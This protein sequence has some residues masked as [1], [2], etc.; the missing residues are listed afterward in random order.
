MSD[1]ELRQLYEQTKE[2]ELQYNECPSDWKENEGRLLSNDKYYDVFTCSKKENDGI[3]NS[4]ILEEG[5]KLYHGSQTLRRN[6][7]KGI[8]TVW[9]LRMGHHLMAE[10]TYN[11]HWEAKILS[12][13]EIGK[14]YVMVYE[15]K[16]PAKLFLMNDI[17]NL[18][19]IVEAKMFPEDI[20]IK[21]LSERE[22]VDDIRNA[23]MLFVHYM[24]WL[25]TGKGGKLLKHLQSGRVGFIAENGVIGEISFDNLVIN[26]H[27]S[28]YVE[29]RFAKY[30]CGWLQQYGYDGYVS[31]RVPTVKNGE[32]FL[33]EGSVT[34]CYAPDFLER[35]FKDFRDISARYDLEVIDF[36]AD[37]DK[38]L[39]KI[40]E[41]V[42]E[43][44]SE[45]RH[46]LRRQFLEDYKYNT[47]YFKE[48]RSEYNFWL[49]GTM[50]KPVDIND[51]QH[52][53]QLCK[54]GS[55]DEMLATYKYAITHNK[56]IK[57]ALSKI[58]DY[59]EGAFSYYLEDF[60]D[61]TEIWRKINDDNTDI[62]SYLEYLC[63]R[64]N[65]AH[66]IDKSIGR[67]SDKP[68]RIPVEEMAIEG[69]ATESRF[70]KEIRRQLAENTGR[71]S[72]T[73]EKKSYAKLHRRRETNDK[74]IVSE[75]P[76]TRER[77]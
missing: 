21:S 75:R 41:I 28:F 35:K 23:F 37:G 5:V 32:V 14:S 42:H 30:F 33:Y 10:T 50:M 40:D 55:L 71:R 60:D 16:K 66:Y 29:H 22:R 34:F 27:E 3:F 17:E 73:G 69:K 65:D 2:D 59:P 15:V 20:Q 12:S 51:T 44:D 26:A 46:Q 56:K 64:I 48:A 74:T 36:Y 54:V 9:P 1:R 77:R 72:P 4:M 61:P 43:E 57:R 7:Q 19:K 47:K 58:H 25:M 63:A 76:L 6:T 31:S 24:L 68:F 53:D 62:M 67:S 18:K 49:Y 39:D 52:Y 13:Q 38:E 45:M 8:D 70:N 11:T